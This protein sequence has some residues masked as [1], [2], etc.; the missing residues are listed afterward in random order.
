MN[1]NANLARPDRCVTTPGLDTLGVTQHSAKAG[2]LVQSCRANITGCEADDDLSH[3]LTASPRREV[4]RCE[5]CAAS[6][7]LRE[8]FGAP[9]DAGLPGEPFRLNRLHYPTLIR[10]ATVPDREAC[11]A[12]V[13][14][15]RF[16]PHA[17]R[18]TVA[19]NAAPEARHA[20]FGA[21]CAAHDHARVRAP[22]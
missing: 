20:T 15:R 9:R 11:T 2:S 5:S 21:H 8:A 12:L 7:V 17:S 13:R 6:V 22:T 19:A 1:R 18:A 10:L 3:P 16:C 4:P 14:P